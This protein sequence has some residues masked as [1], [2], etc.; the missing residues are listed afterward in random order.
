MLWFVLSRSPTD[1]TDTIQQ[2]F[3]EAWSPLFL[4]MGVPEAE[5]NT[6]VVEAKEQLGNPDKLRAYTKWTFACGQK[7]S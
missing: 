3:I 7:T 2:E 4:S 5:V 1:A 6:W